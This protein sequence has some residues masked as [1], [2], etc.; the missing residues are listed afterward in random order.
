MIEAPV[1][2][3]DAPAIP[4]LAFRPFDPE[5]ETIPASST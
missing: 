4:G 5:R 2:L 3:P 1:I